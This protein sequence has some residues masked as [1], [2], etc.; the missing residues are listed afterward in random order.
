[1]NIRKNNLD[2]QFLGSQVFLEHPEDF[3]QIFHNG[4]SEFVRCFFLDVNSCSEP[5]RNPDGSFEVDLQVVLVLTLETMSYFSNQLPV[6][7]RKEYWLGA[8]EA[9]TLSER[10]LRFAFEIHPKNIAA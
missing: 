8:M 2:L 3:T 6:E 7:K 1:M 10:T 4:F 9:L 5:F